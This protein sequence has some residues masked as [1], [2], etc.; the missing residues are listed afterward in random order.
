MRAWGLP[1][2]PW[3]FILDSRGLVQSR[4]EGPIDV[5]ELDLLVRRSLG[6]EVTQP[7][8]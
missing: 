5:T 7:Q 1:S 3:F 6:E 2:E 4:I 8:N